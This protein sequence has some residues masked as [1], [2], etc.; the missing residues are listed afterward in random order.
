MGARSGRRPVL[1]GP[2]CHDDLGLTPPT[3]SHS[4][5]FPH[6]LGG[7]R[8]MLSSRSSRR[9]RSRAGPLTSHHDRRGA[10]AGTEWEG[11]VEKRLAPCPLL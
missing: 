2:V 8:E 3:S 10:T 6:I 5:P 9:H 11:D 7:R 4:G 1:L